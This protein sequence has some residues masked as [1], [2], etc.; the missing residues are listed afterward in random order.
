MSKHLLFPSVVALC[1]ISV[2]GCQTNRPERRD[3]QREAGFHQAAP[4]SDEPTRDPASDESATRERRRERTEEPAPTNT[5][6]PPQQEAPVKT[7][8]LPYAKPVAGKPGFVTSPFA[9]AAG[10]I[11]VRGFPPGTEVKDPYS[12][13]TFLVP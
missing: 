1:A 3:R 8:D 12:G 4:T 5:A 10:Y 7:G 11:D 2:A 13:K 6:P 9:P